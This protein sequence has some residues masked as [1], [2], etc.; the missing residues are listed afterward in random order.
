MVG[1]LYPE[2]MYAA[3]VRFRKDIHIV[4]PNG[5]TVEAWISATINKGGVFLEASE[6]TYKGYI[7][8]H[9]FIPFNDR[10][11]EGEFYDILVEESLDLAVDIS[12][13]MADNDLI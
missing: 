9:R 2:K 4:L 13:F 6:T 3:W 10:L 11:S 8:P 7:L 5:L 1:K 12:D